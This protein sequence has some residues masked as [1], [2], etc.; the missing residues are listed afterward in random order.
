M[1]RI[2]GR[3]PI[4]A[5]D[6]LFCVGLTVGRRI[7]EGGK[8]HR[9]RLR[10]QQARELDDIDLEAPGITELRHEADVGQNA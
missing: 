10:P 5:G 1:V 6:A 7:A 8:L 4:G 3:G 9:R 2:G